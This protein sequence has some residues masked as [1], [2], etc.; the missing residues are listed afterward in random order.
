[1]TDQNN[2]ETAEKPAQKPPTQTIAPAPLIDE[3]DLTPPQGKT[4]E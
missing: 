1:M 2:P 3:D 4:D